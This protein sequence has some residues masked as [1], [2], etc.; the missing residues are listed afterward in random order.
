MDVDVGEI[1]QEVHQEAEQ[2]P[3][4]THE[5]AE[6]VIHRCACTAVTCWNASELCFSIILREPSSARTHL[7]ASPLPSLSGRSDASL[8]DP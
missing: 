2:E 6:D 8:A 1:D 5:E 3:E 7:R 4:E